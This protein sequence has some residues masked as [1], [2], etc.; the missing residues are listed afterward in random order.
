[1]RGFRRNSEDSSIAFLDIICCGFGAIILLL[2]IVKPGS[3]DVLESSDQQQGGRIKVMQEQL[4]QLRGEIDYLEREL[5]VKQEQL[6][7]E[8]ERVAIMRG[9]LDRDGKMLA[10]RQMS[11]IDEE[12]RQEDLR[13]AMQSLS[14]EMRRLL[15][16]AYQRR[17][18]V[19]AVFL[20]TRN[21]LFSLLIP[22]AVCTTTLGGESLMK[23]VTSWTFILIS[24]AY[25]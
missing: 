19:I 10:A 25:R 6:D 2:V 9:E 23:S 1:M 12:E 22:P 8:T 15:G 21:T 7:I 11:Q 3:P 16:D 18:N 20:L 4:F 13:I 14:E 5:T 17:D 24:R